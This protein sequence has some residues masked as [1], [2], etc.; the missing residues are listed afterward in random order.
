VQPSARHSGG[1]GGELKV[2]VREY[3]LVRMESRAGAGLL[4]EI[5]GGS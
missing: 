5:T 3:W 4:A 1:P 2:V